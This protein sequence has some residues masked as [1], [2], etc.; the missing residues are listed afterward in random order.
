MNDRAALEQLA[1]LVGIETQYTDTFGQPHDVADETLLALIDAFGLTADPAVARRELAERQRGAPL[2]VRPVH[3]VDAEAAHPEL[4][5]TLH[6][7]EGCR[8]IRQQSSYI[9]NMPRFGLSSSCRQS[10]Y[11]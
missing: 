2:G 4:K 8:E 3:F 9:T 5:L 10:V 1:R 6:L 7:P 11:S